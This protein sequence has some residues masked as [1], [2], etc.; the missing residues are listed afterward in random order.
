M[1]R[2]FLVAA[3]GAAVAIVTAAAIW[4][5]YAE[6]SHAQPPGAELSGSG[7]H[8]RTSVDDI[9][10]DPPGD[11][12]PNY[13]MA[14]SHAA[15]VSGN[16]SVTVDGGPISSGQ[17]VAGFLLGCG[18]SVAGGV[19]VGIAPNQELDLSISPSLSPPSTDTA[20]PTTTV[21]P[22]TSNHPTVTVTP[23]SG[24]ATAPELS[25]GPSI[26]GAL[27]LSE[28]LSGTLQPGQVTT[29]TTATATLDDKTTFPFHLAFNNSALNVSQCASPVAAVPFVS[30]SV[31]TADGLVQTT[32]YGT[33]F[34]F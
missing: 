3:S 11:R 33:Q 14:F 12:T 20:A 32:A 4:A 19:T 5:G 9:R 16:Y 30:A 23:P 21:T 29:A 6:P 27:G 28:E 13:L 26:G 7:V 22:S 15:Q 24:T 31:S 1:R 25:L 34:S 17:A 2:P 18:I 8:L 10:V